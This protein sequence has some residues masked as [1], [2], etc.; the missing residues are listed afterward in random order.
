MLIVCFFFSSRRRHTRY[1]RDWSSDVCSSDL[2]DGGISFPPLDGWQFYGPAQGVPSAV[3]GVTADQ[4]GNIWVAGGEEGLFLLQPGTST[5]RRFT[6][7]DGLHPYG[8][9]PDG[10]V[11]SGQNYLKVLSV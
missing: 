3:F 4:G 8:Y 5:F 7:A 9:L 6:M 10:G 2:T 11:P 1:W